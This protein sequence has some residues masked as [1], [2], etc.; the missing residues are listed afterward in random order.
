VDDDMN[1]DNDALKILQTSLSLIEN[2]LTQPLKSDDIFRWLGVSKSSF[3]PL[4]KAITGYP[5]NQYIRYR[6]LSEVAY[7][8]QQNPQS[9][10]QLAC[11]YQYQS[12]EAFYRAFKQYFGISIRQF[13]HTNIHTQIFAP[14]TITIIKQGEKVMFN[15]E[16]NQTHINEALLNQPGSYLIDVDIDHF[17]S[18][19]E[20]YGYSIGDAVLAATLL[21][22]KQVC[23]GYENIQGPWRY[24]NDEFLFVTKDHAKEIIGEILR[25]FEVP[26]HIQQYDIDVSIS[27]GA[28]IIADD[29]INR[30]QQSMVNAKHQGRRRADVSQI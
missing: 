7:Q 4:F 27:I 19:N 11:K 6:R 22:I 20:K 13:Q 15:K 30:V 16:M 26:M 5:L 1:V 14:I 21:R 23:D 2:H 8:Y 24:G 17:M 10:S 25:V 12:H 9:A 29:S 28:A 18:I 3:T